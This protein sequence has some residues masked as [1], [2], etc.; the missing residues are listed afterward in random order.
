M[1]LALLAY[2]LRERVLVACRVRERWCGRGREAREG[3]NERQYRR[4]EG[5]REEGRTEKER[6]CACKT[7]GEGG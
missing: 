1:L 2:Q 4:I 3:R 6:T 5:R 7:E